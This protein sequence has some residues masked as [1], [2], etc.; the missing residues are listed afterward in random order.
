MT[1]SKFITG[2]IR[3][4]VLLLCVGVPIQWAAHIRSEAQNE[5]SARD[6]ANMYYGT[7][8]FLAH[9]DLYQTRNDLDQLKADGE[10]LRI[11]FV[12]GR[13][14]SLSGELNQNY[15]PPAY[16]PMAPFAMLARPVSQTLWLSLTA[17]LLAG[18]AFFMW[19]FAGR[20]GTI[21]GFMLGFMVLNCLVVFVVGNPAGIVASL[22]VIAVWCFLRQRFVL[23]GVFMLAVALVMKPH[24]AGFVWLYFLL[25]GGQQRKRSLQ[26][27]AVVA[28]LTVWAVVWIA[29]V[30]PH[31]IQELHSNLTWVSGPGAPSDPGPSG[32]SARDMGAI[33]NLQTAISVFRND[34]RF[35]SL[36]TYLIVGCLILAWVIAVLHK[37]FT[38]EGSLLALAA[39]SILTILPC[40]HRTYDATILMLTVP[41]FAILWLKRGMKRWV[42]LGLTSAAIIAV[43]D[44]PLTLLLHKTQN[45]PVSASTI[46]G[47]LT[48]LALEPTSLV[49]LATG[50]FYLW[51]YIRYEPPSADSAPE[52]AAERWLDTAVAR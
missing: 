35:Y 42:A 51:V 49:L 52:D 24:D 45:I 3:A 13:S 23:F 25:A 40:Y 47:K 6:F 22:S 20:A 39:V 43:G 48:L 18:A 15:L 7:R 27:L 30:S 14:I 19:D 10:S 38:R 4:L 11:M 33:I 50:C 36:V 29:P 28:V 17:V 16:L 9:E 46:S 21:A 2:M 37:P 41:A 1:L 31:W 26:T 12:G 5:M 44:I 32:T 34:P 8:T